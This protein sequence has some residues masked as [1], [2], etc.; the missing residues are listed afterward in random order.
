MRIMC[1]FFRRA[2][3]Q[4]S[5]ESLEW[6]PLTH[7]HT[8]TLILLAWGSSPPL[9]LP[10]S[11]LGHPLHAPYAQLCAA[12][13][14]SLPPLSQKRRIFALFFFLMDMVLSLPIGHA[15]L[16]LLLP[17]ANSALLFAHLRKYYPL[18]H[19]QVLMESLTHTNPHNPFLNYFLYKAS[20]PSGEVFSLN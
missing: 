5:M 6:M 2:P 10:F 16:K 14:N 19:P 17:Q 13:A 8:H 15:M 12:M 7:K 1:S 11:P 18:P 3:P 20:W 4:A 9:P